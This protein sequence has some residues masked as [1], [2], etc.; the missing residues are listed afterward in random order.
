MIN[1]KSKILHAELKNGSHYPYLWLGKDKFADLFNEWDFETN[2]GKFK[3]MLDFDNS[4]SFTIEADEIESIESI[5]GMSFDEDLA[6][7]EVVDFT[8]EDINWE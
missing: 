1:Q 6:D 7:S 5:I 2:E 4:V 8:L 3:G